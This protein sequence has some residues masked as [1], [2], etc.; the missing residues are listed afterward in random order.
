MLAAALPAMADDFTVDGV[1]YSVNTDGITC[2]VGK[3]P[4]AAGDIVVPDKVTFDGKEYRVTTV[5]REA[6]RGNTAMTSIELPNTITRLED[7]CFYESKGL[8][9]A[10]LPSS[11]RTIGAVTFGDCTALEEVTVGEGITYI[12]DGIFSGDVKLRTVSLPSTLVT[13]GNETF[14]NCDSLEDPE[15]PASV[16]QI[17]SRA[18][19]G[20][21]SLENVVISDNIITLESG[22]F[23]G[24][25][26]VKNVTI[27]KSVATIPGDCFLGCSELEKV[28]I[29]PKVSVI[30]W[31]AFSECPKI[32]TV[33]VLATV[34]PE[35]E[36]YSFTTYEATLYVP[37]DA[38]GAYRAHETWAEFAS[39]QP[40]E[41][42]VEGI[43]ADGNAAVEVFDLMGRR[44]FAGE[45]AAISGLE[46]IYVVKEGAR[47][48]KEVF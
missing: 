32:T 16:R 5:G 18:F 44:V 6:F 4:E 35:A 14:K 34:P 11:V 10:N 38:I 13:I 20:C 47:T 36:Y 46:G 48:V 39:I 37:G 9:K 30:E 31:G 42:G 25:K 45:R 26:N 1:I 23:Y 12:G 27:G 40:I 22:A 8:R 43:G 15:I 29:G 28:Q 19:Y 33:E 3:N 41:Q 17:G 21:L 2:S 24:C 7:F